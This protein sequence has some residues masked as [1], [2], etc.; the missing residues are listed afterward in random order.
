MSRARNSLGVSWHGV[1]LRNTVVSTD[2]VRIRQILSNLVSNAWSHGGTTCEI[3]VAATPAI[4]G[5]IDVT[6][7]V[8]DR[9]PGIPAERMVRVLEPF[10]KGEASAGLGLGLALSNQLAKALNGVLSISAR[11]GGGAVVRLTLT[12]PRA[13]MTQSARVT[14]SNAKLRRVLVV[15]DDALSREVIGALLR[16]EGF[17]VE[18]AGSVSS[19]MALA[20]AQHFDATIIDRSLGGEDGIELLSAFRGDPNAFGNP[21]A[22]IMSASVQDDLRARARDLGADSVLEKPVSRAT[23]REALGQPAKDAPPGGRIDELRA[24]LG[25]EADRLLADV[26][27]EAMHVIER[28]ESAVQVGDG[29]VA[30][31]L[32]HRLRG[33][34]ATFGLNELAA[35]AHAF[36]LNEPEAT[37]ARLRAA[38]DATRGDIQTGA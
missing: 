11:D 31:E 14:E 28:I 29:A 8:M 12:L 19:A 3:E 32:A 7:D 38:A 25:G 1:S 30:Q 18:E 16:M 2:G 34:A 26:H 15:E 37:I 5:R 21:C 6:F 22:V 20:R 36:E 13:A 35:A 4:D 23:L 10:E 27:P 33:L 9:G 17:H 24:A